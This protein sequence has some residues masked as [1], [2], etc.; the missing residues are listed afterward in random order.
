MASLIKNQIVKHLSTFAR[1]LKPEQISL[2]VL[3]GKGQ[4]RNLELN[5]EVISERLEFPPWLKIVK[6]HCSSVTVKIPWTQI[7][8]APVQLYVEELQVVIRLVTPTSP[9]IS[10]KTSP[11]QFI[12]NLKSNKSY[13]LPERVLECLSLYV[14]SIEI[15]FETES[16]STI[17]FGGSIML[18]HLVLESRMPNF[19][20]WPNGQI[21]K[22]NMTRI[23]ERTLGQVLFFKHV[24]WRVLKIEASHNNNNNLNEKQTRRGSAL[25]SPLRLL[26]ENGRCRI[27][28]KKNTADCSLI[29]GRMELLFDEIHWLAYMA[30]LRSA[31]DFYQHIMYLA[32]LSS[33]ILP[34]Q[35]SVHQFVDQQK[36]AT[37][38]AS[39][40]PHVSSS[41]INVFRQH[42]ITQS[43]HHLLI[44]RIDL[45]LCDD[46][47]AEDL[48]PD[49]NI[50]SGAMQA[51][52]LKLRVDFYPQ[53]KVFETDG[54]QSSRSNWLRY[55]A[56]NTFT[57]L[58]TRQLD[59]HFGLINSKMDS[60]TRLRFERIWPQLVSANVVIR[61]EDLIIQ[62]ISERNT[63]KEDIAYL[64][65]VNQSL[66]NRMPQPLSF[67]HLE[68][69]SYNFPATDSY[70][71]P[72]NS[73]YL[74]LAPFV[75]IPDTKSIRWL[76]YAFENILNSFEAPQ[77]SIIKQDN[78]NDKQVEI[79]IE[80]IMPKIM[81]NPD[82]LTLTAPTLNNKKEDEEETK[83]KFSSS[84]NN[85]DKQQPLPP[86]P[87]TINSPIF[88]KR[89]FIHLTTIL[90]S[91]YTLLSDTD[92]NIQLKF[93]LVLKSKAQR[94]STLNFIKFVENLCFN[95]SIGEEKEEYLMLQTILRRIEESDKI[96]NLICDNENEE[97]YF[98][99]PTLWVDCDFGPNTWELPLIN[100]LN[101]FGSL[102]CLIDRE[103]KIKGNCVQI[104]PRSNID[105]V[106]DHF[107]YVQIEKLGDLIT[108]LIDQ[109]NSDRQFFAKHQIDNFHNSIP[110]S[111][112]LHCKKINLHL[113]LPQGL[114][115][116]P[117]DNNY[118]FE[119]F[120]PL[121]VYQSSS[122]TSSHAIN[123]ETP[124]SPSLSQ[125]TTNTKLLIYPQQMTTTKSATSLVNSSLNEKQTPKSV[126][127]QQLHPKSARGSLT[128]TETSLGNYGKVKG[129]KTVS[130][131]PRVCDVL[132]ENVVQSDKKQQQKI[133]NYMGQTISSPSSDFCR[134]ST[135]T[136]GDLESNFDETISITSV[137]TEQICFDSIL[138]DREESEIFDEDEEGIVEA[139][140]ANEEEEDFCENKQLKQQQNNKNNLQI[141]RLK[142]KFFG[143]EINCFDVIIE[144]FNFYL[145]LN[146]GNTKAFGFA[147][148]LNVDER[149]HVVCGKIY[150]ERKESSSSN[151][152][153][154]T[155]SPTKI[156]DES[157]EIFDTINPMDFAQLK[158]ELNS[159]GKESNLKLNI[160]GI[161]IH[162]EKEIVSQLGPFFENQEVLNDSS[163]AAIELIL[164][165]CNIE[166]KVCL[167][168]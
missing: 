10:K 145:N 103:G 135:T 27:T 12:F 126:Q 64:I 110:I 136:P 121:E 130:S 109:I 150:N 118:N 95:N 127:Q 114:S 9:N 153:D 67:A 3:R 138:N 120:T 52:I 132:N 101:I 152:I 29:A 26:T 133:I 108:E 69:T 40:A 30:H 15:Y 102:N 167:G 39:S 20:E 36:N 86:P 25:N 142:E 4:L 158:I 128:M 87:T 71:V 56:P 74:M 119:F 70:P 77:H 90:F 51:T 156:N 2:E 14:Q 84:N 113:V 106:L 41:N 47:S 151:T 76:I 6:A 91:N 50:D 165:N 1:N 72:P 148:S 21:P 46:S 68:I 31:I 49:W 16:N 134:M 81:L 24:S 75:L 146:D 73:V 122:E 149:L 144:D 43:S 162:L 160:D 107:Q 54:K 88:P 65:E 96:K 161:N 117:Y 92:I 116:S 98:S 42:D 83:R 97:W 48:P 5:E 62:A 37:V 61:I 33:N 85:Q 112:Y 80:M 59:H 11:T 19:H 143:R 32:N 164:Q 13:D 154:E 131:L 28:I 166:I 147:K 155:L 79:R 104:E 111:I 35:L 17:N 124:N 57:D 89:F 34:K 99:V 94:Y 141:L 129:I 93:P 82:N 18:S 168:N 66:K 137:S 100:D 140:E 22:I 78:S 23:H 7:K 123:Y 139:E 105:V 163:K 159:V 55:V 38:S 60:N 45:H 8:S 44:S 63:K 115:P 58:A 125:Q 53:H 157:E